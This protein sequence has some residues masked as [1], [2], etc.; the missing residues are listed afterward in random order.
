M[1]SKVPIFTL[2]NLRKFPKFS[3][4]IR[5]IWFILGLMALLWAADNPVLPAGLSFKTIKT[6][7]PSEHRQRF[8][9][10]ERLIR[11]GDLIAA[12]QVYLQI[13]AQKDNFFAY[14]GSGWCL[15]QSRRTREAEKAYARANNLRKKNYAF[16]IDYAEFTAS[17]RPR[18]E[19]LAD[20][21]QRAYRLQPNEEPLHLLL[22]AAQ[23][24]ERLAEALTILQSLSSQDSV[25]LTVM[26]YSAT[27][28]EKLGRGDEAIQMIISSSALVKDPFQMRLMVT[29]LA[30]HGRFI[31]AARICERLSADYPRSAEALEAWAYLEYKGG[32]YQNAADQYLRAL[33]RAY[34][35]PTVLMLAR[36]HHYHLQNPRKALYYCKAAL[37]LDRQSADAYFLMAEIYRRKGDLPRALRYSEKQLQYSPQKSISNFYHGKLYFEMQD[38]PRAV[39]Y[40]QK[41]VDLNPARQRYRLIL[42]KAYAGAGQPDRAR[43]VYAEFLNEP[44]SDLWQEEERL[45]DT[46]PELE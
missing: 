26:I 13:L 17:D 37:Q 15:R 44:V 45:R 34:R 20:L 39:L 35:L 28:L 2:N 3:A 18:W 22:S 25:D 21:V 27:V 7:V 14:W 11:K 43:A 42:A 10:A 4:M 29:I 46:A 12:N 36:I 9:K 31:E 19:R 16:L 23:R 24:D 41:A 38:Y 30:N 32:R 8:K 5:R 6:A 33:N 40:L 1:V